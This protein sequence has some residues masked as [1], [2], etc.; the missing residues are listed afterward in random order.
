MHTVIKRNE[1]YIKRNIFITFTG[2]LF[3]SINENLCNWSLCRKI[4]DLCLNKNK[5]KITTKSLAMKIL[6][7]NHQG[8]VPIFPDD[9]YSI[10]L[11]FLSPKNIVNCRAISRE[12]YKH[13]N[14]LLL[15][16]KI[17]KTIGVDHGIC[18]AT[19]DIEN[20]LLKKEVIS[21]PINLKKKI[22]QFFN[23]F[24]KN[25]TRALK[26]ISAKDS[27]CYGLYI[28][29]TNS[30]VI[31]KL[32]SI[33]C[34]KFEVANEF[35][36]SIDTRLTII[37]ENRADNPDKFVMERNSLNYSSNGPVPVGNNNHSFDRSFL[38]KSNKVDQ[39]LEIFIFKQ[40][41]K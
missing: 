22:A 20:T 38:I 23:N 34:R 36:K 37:G 1:I 21:D 2:A 18:D 5:A 41:D 14:S 13:T 11:S 35:F 16:Q 6:S 30:D 12:W 32:K 24:G 31:L 19:Q 25:E 40:L 17:A 7:K 33:Q 28:K 10:I 15:W 4:L 3:L 9:I 39:N 26:Y 8:K 29:T 27:G